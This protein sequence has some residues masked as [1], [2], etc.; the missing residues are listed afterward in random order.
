MTTADISPFNPPGAKPDRTNAERQRQFHGRRKAKSPVT[1]P[2][3]AMPAVTTVPATAGID[4]AAL[5]APIALTGAAAFFFHQGHGGVVPRRAALSRNHGIRY[6]RGQARNGRMLARRWRVTGRVRRLTLVV[7][8]AGLAV[9][10]A[11]GVYA[12]LVAGCAPENRRIV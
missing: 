4:V 2:P 1:A 5:A 7:L 12:Q 6:G 11:T 8:I 3:A 9:I 10:N